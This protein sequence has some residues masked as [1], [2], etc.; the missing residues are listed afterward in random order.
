MPVKSYA[1]VTLTAPQP[2][3]HSPTQKRNVLSSSSHCNIGCGGSIRPCLRHHSRHQLVQSN[4]IGLLLA[5][6]LLPPVKGINAP[7]TQGL[8]TPLC[9][10]LSSTQLYNT[11]CTMS[12]TCFVAALHIEV[13]A[14]DGRAKIPST[15]G[16]PPI[17]TPIAL[18]RRPRRAA[19]L[20]QWWEQ[21]CW[22][23]RSS[24]RRP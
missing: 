13:E 2:A 24:L 7:C 22:L 11:A 14:T 10:L 1:A 3:L 4:I 20:L 15:Y 8:C 16:K 18:R 19:W 6:R 17:E 12:E 23:G 21:R 5:G 9:T